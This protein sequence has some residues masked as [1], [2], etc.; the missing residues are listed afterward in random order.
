MFDKINVPFDPKHESQIMGRI[1]VKL[2]LFNY[3]L[4]VNFLPDPIVKVEHISIRN[5]DL[6][7]TVAKTSRN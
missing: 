6:A 4:E 7:Q 2:L 1:Y 3:N 5:L